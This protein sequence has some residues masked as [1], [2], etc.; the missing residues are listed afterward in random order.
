MFPGTRQD[1]GMTVFG[2]EDWSS[3]YRD[4]VI[5]WDL[6]Q[7]HPEL[8]RRLPSLGPPGTALVPG[9]GRG[10]DAAALAAAGW[11]VTAIDYAP[12][13]EAD[14]RDAVGSEGSVV[15]GNV[16][17]FAPLEPVDLLFDHTFFCTL[18]PAHRAGFGV[19]AAQVVKPDGRVA[20]VAFPIDLPKSEGVPPYPMT[21]D[22]LAAALG[23]GFTLELDEPADR[24]GRTWDTRWAVLRH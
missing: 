9:A 8:V 4:G 21:V 1:V 16:F 14:L 13:V 2:P 20:S 10:H 5:P 19:W 6:G 17:E 3:H 24:A 18:P 23:S 15:T 12:E 7:A 11:Q 22:D